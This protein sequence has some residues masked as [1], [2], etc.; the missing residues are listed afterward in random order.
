MLSSVGPPTLYPA[1]DVDLTLTLA[2]LA[3]EAVR[4]N[5]PLSAA[6][7]FSAIETANPELAEDGAP[8]SAFLTA[9]L[10][11]LFAYTRCLAEEMSVHTAGRLEVHTGEEVSSHSHL[12]GYCLNCA[13]TW[14]GTGPMIIERARLHARRHRHTTVVDSSRTHIFQFGEKIVEGSEEDDAGSETPTA[15]L[16]LAV[17]GA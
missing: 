16:R 14:R 7:V 8:R 3:E 12:A 13:T 1:L 5:R 6:E 10:A 15:E 4:H 9:A 2:E 17:M 11:N